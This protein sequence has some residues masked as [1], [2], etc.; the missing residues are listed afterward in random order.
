M[1]KSRSFESD[2]NIDLL[3]IQVLV[4]KFKVGLLLYCV[5]VLAPKYIFIG[6]S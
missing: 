5:V 4:T 3:D 6:R 1:K 2:P